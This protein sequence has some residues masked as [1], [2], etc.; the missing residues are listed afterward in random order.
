MGSKDSGKFYWREHRL[1]PLGPV[2][3]NDHYLCRL[4]QIR[5]FFHPMICSIRA[6]FFYLVIKV[7]INSSMT[8]ISCE[9]WISI[10]ISIY[11]CVYIYLSP[12][13]G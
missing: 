8:S 3:S 11:M 5:T 4:M 10:L 13:L 7:L 1:E 12:F 2:W 6:G 9:C